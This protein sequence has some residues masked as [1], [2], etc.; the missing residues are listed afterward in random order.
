MGFFSD[1][2]GAALGG[3]KD[4]NDRAMEYYY[5]AMDMS[6]DRFRREFERFGHD[7]SNKARY[8]GYRRAAQERGL[9]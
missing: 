5:K 9:I 2:G 1:L 8:F 4:W 7:S 6:D 3:I